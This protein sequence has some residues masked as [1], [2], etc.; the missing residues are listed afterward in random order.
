M[1]RNK[2]IP[3]LEAAL[4][5]DFSELKAGEENIKIEESKKKV[6]EEVLEPK[7]GLK[8]DAVESRE[9]FIS[10]PIEATK[11]IVEDS[12]E[13]KQNE[14]T[15]KE[16]VAPIKEKEILNEPTSKIGDDFDVGW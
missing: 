7:Y 4:E 6:S 3:N 8:I 9:K 2:D 14:D 16:D 12:I 5:R 11:K 15:K 1:A 13:V 10:K